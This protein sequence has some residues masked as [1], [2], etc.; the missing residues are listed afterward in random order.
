MTEH[1]T[2]QKAYEYIEHMEER[3]HD[4][5]ELKD[6]LADAIRN[7]KQLRV[8]FGTWDQVSLNGVEERV[9]RTQALYCTECSPKMEKRNLN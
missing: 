8:A 1:I 7:A 3:G 4:V 6:E 5:E 9:L 2:L